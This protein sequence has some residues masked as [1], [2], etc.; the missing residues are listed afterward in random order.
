MELTEEQKAEIKNYIIDV[1]KYR[2]TYN[3]LYDHILNSLKDNDGSYSIDAVNVIINNDFGGFSEIVEQEKIY[4]KEIGKKYNLYFRSEMLHTFQWPGIVNNL[5]LL[6][7]CLLIYYG[8]KGGSYNI[9]PMFFAS[10]I[11]VTG[12]ALFG[13]FKIIVN[14]LKW[15]KYSI[16]DNCMGFE[17]SF[18]FIVMN[19]FLQVLFG[20]PIW[21]EVSD[22]GKLIITLCLFF[23]CSLYVRTFV[24]FY[25]KKFKVLIA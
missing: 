2:E 10:T 20:K 4:Q 21:F 18:G 3:E 25:N 12:V 15:S 6:V 1:P 9:K 16:L 13:Y 14:K 22:H 11:C 23:F 8:N 17:C 19:G 7:L 24:K 5:S